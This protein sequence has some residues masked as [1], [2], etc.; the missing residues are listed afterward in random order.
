MMFSTC[1]Q[2]ALQFK[3]IRW[4]TTTNEASDSDSK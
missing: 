3:L 4:D 1:A 2:W